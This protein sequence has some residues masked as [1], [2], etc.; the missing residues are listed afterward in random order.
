MLKEKELNQIKE[1]LDNCKCPMY[2]FGDDQDALCSFLILYKYKREGKGIVV[3]GNS[4]I[5]KFFSN[6]VNEYGADKVFVLDMPKIQ[7]D[8]IEN[9]NVL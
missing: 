4:S 3:K 7:D 5:N 8:F 9:V 1:E 6:K 2:L